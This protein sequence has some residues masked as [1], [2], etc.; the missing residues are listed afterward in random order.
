MKAHL[1]EL[2]HMAAQALVRLFGGTEKQIT[3][4]S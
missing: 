4:D 2:F 3:G 1:G